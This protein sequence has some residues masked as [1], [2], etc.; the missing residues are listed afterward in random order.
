M[1]EVQKI[2]FSDLDRF[3]TA[4]E[5]ISELKVSRNDLSNY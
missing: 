5:R 2:F 3:D 4:K 1:K